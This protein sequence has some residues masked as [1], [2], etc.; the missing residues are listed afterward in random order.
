MACTNALFDLAL[1]SS[2]GSLAL[3]RYARLF[4]GSLARSLARSLSLSLSPLFVSLLSCIFC[5]HS[6]LFSV[7]HHGTPLFYLS[8]S[9]MPEAL[10][11][12]DGPRNCPHHLGWSPCPG[13]L[14]FRVWVRSMV[15]LHI[16]PANL[17]R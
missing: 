1:G 2:F 14:P 3:A 8:S 11:I 17:L 9:N 10:A 5:L 4:L 7:P 15:L 6:S 16:L 12:Q 13:A